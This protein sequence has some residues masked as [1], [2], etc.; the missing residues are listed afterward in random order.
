MSYLEANQTITPDKNQPE[1][2]SHNRSEPAFLVVGRIRRSH[3]IRGEVVMELISDFPER[4]RIGTVLFIGDNHT[5]VR[6]LSR[7]MHSEGM[8]ILF[9]NYS[10]PE[11]HDSLRNQWVFVRAN[12]RPPLPEGEYYHHQIIG[13]SVV[14]DTGQ[15]L[16]TVI[17]IIETGANEVY[18]IRP[19]TGPELLIPAIP[20]VIQEISLE[21]A[22]LQIH[23]LPG[24]LPD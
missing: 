21:K 15:E 8:L 22:V 16:G 9:E 17:D 6:V 13:L 24:L 1:A 12:D 20:S 18:I 11:S 3:G 10:S 23:L 19:E 5:P 7:R 2:D 14:S 4:I